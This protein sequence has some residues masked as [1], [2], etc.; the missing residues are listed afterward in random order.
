MPGEGAFNLDTTVN[1]L[2]ELNAAFQ[3]MCVRLREAL[4]ET[5]AARTLAIQSRM[6]ALQAQM[7]PHF[8]Y[9]M[10]ATISI[11]AEK[12]ESAQI[13]AICESLGGHDGLYLH[14]RRSVR[15]HRRR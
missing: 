3:T 13:V 5:V 6:L 14:R 4:D 12:G 1:E 15:D 9:N 7:D 11:L 8:L 10:I 2:E